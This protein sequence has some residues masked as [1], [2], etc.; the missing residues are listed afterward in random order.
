MKQR[1]LAIVI[2]LNICANLN[3]YNYGT[4]EG[5]IKGCEEG[6][7]KACNDLAGMYLTG[8]TAYYHVKSDK[9]KAKEFYDKSM[10]LYQKY[11]DE[12]NAKA[13]FELGDKYNGMRW[14]IEQNLTMMMKYYTMSCELDYGFACN[15][16]GAAY[17]RGTGVNKDSAKSKMYYDK[18]ILLYEKDCKNNI[19]ASCDRLATIFSLQ[20]YGTND[21]KKGLALQKKT[22]RLYMDLCEQNNAEGCYQVATSYYHASRT[23]E[24]DWSQAK[25]YYQ[26]SCKLGESSACNEAKEID[27]NEQIKYE[28]KME[29]AQ[30]NFQYFAKR[31]EEEDKWNAR[32]TQQQEE[33]LDSNL[34]R[35]E[36]EKLLKK[37]ESENILWKEESD[38]R[39]EEAKMI[40][41]QKQKEIEAF[42]K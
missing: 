3:A 6:H 30:L 23:V 36:Q 18:A 12:G 7:A 13:C 8:D 31:K 40:L 22:F 4:L 24:L 11:C 34:T 2:I 29:L 27:P 1:L 15:E 32:R 14:G 37:M 38:K 5:N 33:L 26:K 17:K 42:L 39:L 28:K 35:V 21:Q 20:M 9:K 41:D 10:Q 25:Y 16:L 19:A